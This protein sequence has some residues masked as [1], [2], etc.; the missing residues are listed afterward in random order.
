MRVILIIPG[1][2]P[3]MILRPLAATAVLVLVASGCG[4]SSTPQDAEPSVVVTYS[5]LGAV[6]SELVGDAASVTVLIPDGVDPHDWEPSPRDIEAVANADLVVSNGFD[7][8][9]SLVDVIESEA[10]TWFAAGDHLEP[11]YI[12]QAEDPHFWMDPVAMRDVMTALAPVLADVGIDTGDRL[13]TVSGELDAL[14][15]Q[16]DEMF[17]GLPLDDRLIVTG[18]ES[19][20]WFADRFDFEVVGTV[21]PSLT[22]QAEASAGDLAALT[23]VIEQTGVSTVFTELGTPASVVEAIADATGAE[24]VE[25]STHDLPDD[26]TYRSFMLDLAERISTGVMGERAS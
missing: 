14:L 19:L 3:S 13:R 7:L 12:A 1:A 21:I 26:G 18:H 8:E 5:V 20:G 22:S 9:E 2:P 10:S 24:V 15:A 11:R 6:V 23:D 17:L 16:V 25:I 4:A